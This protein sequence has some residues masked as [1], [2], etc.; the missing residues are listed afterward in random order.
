MTGPTGRRSLLIARH[1]IVPAY[2]TYGD[3]WGLESGAP[4]VHLGVTMERPWVDA[5]ADGRRDANV[6]RFVPGRY[7]VVMAFSPHFGWRLPHFCGVPDVTSAEIPGEPCATTALIHPANWPWQLAGCI[8]VGAAQTKVR[9]DGPSVP[10][11]EDPRYPRLPGES[12]SGIT[13]SV[14]TVRALLRWL[15]AAARGAFDAT[16]MDGFG[17]PM[18]TPPEPSLD[19]IQGD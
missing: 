16:V 1:V 12:Y 6:S 9:Y 5:D 2:A 19:A 15:D 11:A 17:T 8:A 14:A 4:P 10:A 13:S 3:A 7:R 18:G